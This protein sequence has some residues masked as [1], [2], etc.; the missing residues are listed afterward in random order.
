[1]AKKRKKPR[2]AKRT[3]VIDSVVGNQQKINGIDIYKV[4]HAL[5]IMAKS[6]D[7]KKDK[8]LM[9]ATEKLLQRRKQ[10]LR[11]VEKIIAK[12]MRK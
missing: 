10:A 8:K 7:F 3:E 5:D 11:E 12:R 4:E 2:R 9:S 6:E 1:M